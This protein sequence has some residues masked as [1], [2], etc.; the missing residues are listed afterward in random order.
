MNQVLNSK[1]LFVIF[2]FV[3]TFGNIAQKSLLPIQN[4]TLPVLV[5][6]NNNIYASGFYYRDNAFT[7]FV[8]ARHVIFSNVSF[9]LLSDTLTLISYSD[10]FNYKSKNVLQLPLREL[11]K[12]KLVKYHKKYDMAIIRIGEVVKNGDVRIYKPITSTK[13]SN[14]GLLMIQAQSIKSFDSVIV[15]NDAYIMGYPRAIGIKNIPQINYDIPLL[16]KGSIAGKNKDLRTIILDCHVYGGNSGG[17]V[18]EVDKINSEH[19]QYFIIGIISQYIPW[20]SPTIKGNDSTISNSGYSIVVPADI[21]FTLI[22]NWANTYK[23]G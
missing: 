22:S 17:P 12:D 19:S 6:S 7:Y 23:H 10:E 14:T 1:I 20:I 13:H 18:I 5:K 16:K 9:K 21:I 15:S 4:L 11:L 8:T 2:F 3:F